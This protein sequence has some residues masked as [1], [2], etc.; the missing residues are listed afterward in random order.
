MLSFAATVA[1]SEVRRFGHERMEYGFHVSEEIFRS[2]F[3]VKH[4]RMADNAPSFVNLELA[5]AQ[6]GESGAKCWISPNNLR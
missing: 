4:V 3:H 5:V 1:M 6:R 2:I